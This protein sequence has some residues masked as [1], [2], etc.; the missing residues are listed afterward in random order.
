MTD[1]RRTVN[2]KQRKH[3]VAVGGISAPLSLVLV[4]LIRDIW[5]KPM[6]EE[7]IIGFSTLMGSATSVATIC[8][9]DL[10]GV[11]LSRL[12]RRRQTDKC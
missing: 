6:S 4:F 11:I 8:F 12:R 7:L 3:R 10:R 2:D 5:G 1:E 9:W